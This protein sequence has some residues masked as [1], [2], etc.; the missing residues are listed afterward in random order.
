MTFMEWVRLFGAMGTWALIGCVAVVGRDMH[1][2]L[3]KI[4][5][6]ENDPRVDALSIWVEEYRT[7]APRAGTKYFR[8]REA[9]LYE[10]I[11]GKPAPGEVR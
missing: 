8:R 4:E 3:K 2:R 9:K 5:G 7:A 11:T 6:I 1:R 10:A